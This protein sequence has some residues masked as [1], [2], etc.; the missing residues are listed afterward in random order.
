MTGR[1]GAALG[2]RRR[3]ERSVCVSELAR[4]LGTEQVIDPSHD[5][6]VAVVRQLTGGEGVDKALDC[7]GS[8]GAQRLLIDCTRPRGSIAFVGEGGR[9][10]L[11]TSRDLLRT[12][13][14]LHGSWHYNLGRVHRLLQLIRR[15][16]DQIDLLITHRFPISQVAEAWE[17]QLTGACGKVLLQPW[18]EVSKAGRL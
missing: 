2:A 13:I 18:Q 1:P 12:G 5:D 7:S 16:P 4:R 11:D 8:P 3:G 10:D 6:A 17:L 14:T 15:A 9:L